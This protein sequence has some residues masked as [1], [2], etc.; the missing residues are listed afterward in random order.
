MFSTKEWEF[1]EYAGKEN[2]FCLCEGR[3]AA[4][5]THRQYVQNPVTLCF[6]NIEKMRVGCPMKTL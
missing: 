1:T 2:S 3:R 6:I 4:V 5:Q